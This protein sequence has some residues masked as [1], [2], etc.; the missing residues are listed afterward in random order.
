MQPVLLISATLVAIFGTT[1]GLLLEKETRLRIEVLVHLAT[2]AL[3]GITAF[4]ILPEAKAVLS[5]PVFFIAAAIGYLILWAV[6]K[7]VFYVCPSCALAHAEDTSLARKGSLILLATALGIHCILDGLAIST[8]GLL[9]SRA[10]L[11]AI[12]AVGLHKFPEG[13][14]LGIVLAGA[15]YKT[16]RAFAFAS[17][18]ES[19]TIVGGFLSFVLPMHPTPASIGV[20][21][22]V[23]GGSFVYLVCNAMAGALTHQ[24]H[25][26]RIQTI[27]I[28]ACSFLA[29]GA[30]ILAASRG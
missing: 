26:P 13:L 10:E 16:S 15:K 23:I 4:D 9:S 3:L 29:T 14:A 24:S 28:E 17:L 25:L 2:G 1:I 7:F 19:L 6:G 18:V 20:I 8:G 22:A 5:W 30:I 12:L 21:F 27:A 11:G